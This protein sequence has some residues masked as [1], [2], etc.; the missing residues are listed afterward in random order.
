[1]NSKDVIYKNSITLY[2]DTEIMRNNAEYFKFL[3]NTPEIYTIV[4]HKPCSQFLS[5]TI[6]QSIKWGNKKIKK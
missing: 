6:V 2:I 3:E 5:L 1:M 4:F